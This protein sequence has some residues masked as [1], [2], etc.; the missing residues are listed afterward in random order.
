MPFIK[1]VFFANIYLLT[2]KFSQQN[3]KLNNYNFNKYI[4]KT[5]FQ[6]GGIHGWSIKKKVDVWWWLF[7]CCRSYEYKTH[8]GDDN[9]WIFNITKTRVYEAWCLTKFTLPLSILALKLPGGHLN[10]ITTL[11]AFLLLV[12]YFFGF[13]V[14]L[15]NLKR[16]LYF[17]WCWL[18]ISR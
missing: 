12:K 4:K 8:W 7:C 6:S 18:K 3:K 5:K 11:E 10:L 2:N 1:K 9:L 13:F 14:S 17:S 15:Q 16:T